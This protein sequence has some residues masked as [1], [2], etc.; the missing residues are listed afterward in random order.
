MTYYERHKDDCLAYAAM[1]RANYT[2]DDFKKRK[3]YY[4]KYW[5]Q[6]KIKIC[7][8][9]KLKRR[10]KQEEKQKTSQPEQQKMPEPVVETPTP[11]PAVSV[12][13]KRN[14][15]RYPK[16]TG[17]GRGKGK[18]KIP[19]E[20]YKTVVPE[21]FGFEH[22]NSTQK[23]ILKTIAPSGWYERPPEENPFVLKWD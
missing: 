3:D 20:Y 5:Q 9:Q 2:E 18:V 11:V 12:K 8:R 16:G 1:V 23:G 10:L 6:N 4:D 21:P 15:F 14:R 22:L 7:E 19:R 13:R 17:P